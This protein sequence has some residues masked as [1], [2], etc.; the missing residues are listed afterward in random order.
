MKELES[1]AKQISEDKKWGD[2][3]AVKNIPVALIQNSLRLMF[4]G[5]EE[6]GWN[7]IW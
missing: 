2:K 3:Y 5:H 1:Q 7:I 6:L 4:K